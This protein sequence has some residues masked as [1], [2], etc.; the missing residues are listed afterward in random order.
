M[1]KDNTSQ[2]SKAEI[3]KMFRQSIAPYSKKLVALH[4]HLY[5][6]LY[7]RA[8]EIQ[9]LDKIL[10]HLIVADE[11]AK[12]HRYG[13]FPSILHAIKDALHGQ[14]PLSWWNLVTASLGYV[15]KGVTDKSK[16]LQ[17]LK[18]L[19]S[20]SEILTHVIRNFQ[21]PNTKLLLDIRLTALE[22]DARIVELE[23]IPDGVQEIN[24]TLEYL[25]SEYQLLIQELQKVARLPKKDWSQSGERLLYY[26]E[27]AN[28][29]M[30]ILQNIQ[31]TDLETFRNFSNLDHLAVLHQGLYDFIKELNIPEDEINHWQKSE[32]FI[33]FELF[34]YFPDLMLLLSPKQMYS[35]L[36]RA[37]NLFLADQNLD[38]VRPAIF[39][40]PGL[41]NYVLYYEQLTKEQFE[42]FKD[43]AK[44]IKVDPPLKKDPASYYR[45]FFVI[46]NDL[47][48]LCNLI[49]TKKGELSSIK[50]DPNQIQREI[51]NRMIILANSSQPKVLDAILKTFTEEQKENR[52]FLLQEVILEQFIR[53]RKQGIY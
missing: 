12:A 16:N 41:K 11:E 30:S 28:R 24:Q 23:K 34:T 37:E 8:S 22:V 1:A 42:Y 52:Y 36:E 19:K 26:I 45:E 7:R 5:G 3:L 29:L 35:I 2:Q 49:H 21:S 50:C 44:G 51:L 48:H 27:K 40:S 17:E 46:E 18:Y 43:V 32:L 33:V 9:A 14:P 6:N 13:L 10:E 25:I 4:P 53:W 15:F 47:H 39:Y 20:I 31:L 38:K